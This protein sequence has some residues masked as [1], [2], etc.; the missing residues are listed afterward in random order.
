MLPLVHSDKTVY[1]AHSESMDPLSGELVN[2]PKPRRNARRI[3]FASGLAALVGVA[4]V[5]CGGGGDSTQQPEAAVQAVERAQALGLL[6]RLPVSWAPSAIAFSANPGSRQDVPI[7]LT[8]TKALVNAKIVFVPDLRNAVTVTPDT[9]ASLA[10]GQSATVILSFAP[11]ATDTRKVIAG[12]VLL[13][14][15]NATTSK[16]LPVKVSL[17]APESINGITVPPEPPVDLNNATLAGFD[18]NGNG[19]RDDVERALAAKFGGSA[20]YAS[21]LAYARTIQEML[22]VPTPA[23]R[24]DALLLESKWMCGMNGASLSVLNFDMVK[25]MVTTN[26][27]KSARRAFENV[28]IGFGPEELSPC[29]N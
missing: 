16:P 15:K 5:A 12:I 3:L 4:L 19:V 27:R 6:D 2:Q 11:A 14:D 1:Q 25:L 17:V 20:D 10:A 26:S 23:N 24:G 18:T 21:S 9:I 8:T 22:S 29:A 28:L 7:T 13:F